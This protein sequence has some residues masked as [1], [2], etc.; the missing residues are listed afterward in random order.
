MRLAFIA[1]GLSYGG[2]E[3]ILVFVATG[4]LDKGHSVAIINTN[5]HQGVSQQ[6]PDSLVVYNAP[7]EAKH[8]KWALLRR[9]LFCI[10]STR[11]FKPDVVIG[12]L[13]YPNLFSV[14]TG[15]ILHIPS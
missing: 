12:F 9:L 14:L 5:E 8:N 2:A 13:A 11:A 7:K 4:L 10:K 15:K 1:N 3:K 6:I